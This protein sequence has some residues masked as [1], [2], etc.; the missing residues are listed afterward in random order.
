MIK[1]RC[2]N[3]W[4]SQR[5]NKN[6]LK[7]KEINKKPLHLSLIFLHRWCLI[8]NIYLTRCFERSVDLGGGRISPQPLPWEFFKPRAPPTLLHDPQLHFLFLLKDTYSNV[9]RSQIIVR[10]SD[11]W[12]ERERWCAQQGRMHHVRMYHV[13]F[14]GTNCRASI[15]GISTA[16]TKHP[17]LPD[18]FEMEIDSLADI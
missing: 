14:L 16:L 11:N 5:I 8:R 17:H 18:S 15:S 6:A 13:Q 1:I 4:D 3:L 12:S 7:Q 10:L 2:I 9:F